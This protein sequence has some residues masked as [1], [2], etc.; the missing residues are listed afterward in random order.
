M[1]M[2][3]PCHDGPHKALFLDQN[4]F[5]HWYDQN[6]LI[7]GIFVGKKSAFYL[8]HNLSLHYL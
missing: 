1:T 6:A 8:L 4:S 5:S 3:F 2:F 7:F